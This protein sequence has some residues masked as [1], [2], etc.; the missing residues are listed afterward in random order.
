[1]VRV[2]ALPVCV[3]VVTETTKVLLFLA[4]E[5]RLPQG[6]RAEI[7]NTS[8]STFSFSGENT[9]TILPSSASDFDLKFLRILE[10]P[11]WR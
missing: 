9:V 5:Y 1:M 10:G 3:F 2:G 8:F 11:R 6:K 4:E 7:W